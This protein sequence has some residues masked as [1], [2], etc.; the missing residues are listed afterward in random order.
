MVDYA[1]SFVPALTASDVIFNAGSGLL[2]GPLTLGSNEPVE[3]EL[4]VTQ[5]TAPAAG[6]TALSLTTNAETDGTRLRQGTVLHFG[7]KVAVVS[8]TTVVAA[9]STATSVPVEPLAA[10]GDPPSVVAAN[11]KASIWPLL[12]VLAPTDIPLTYTDEKVSSKNLT[13]GLQGAE[14]PVGVMAS[15]QIAI[16]N[17]PDDRAYHGIIYP[18][19]QSKVRIFAHIV[20]NNGNHL[21]GPVYVGAVTDAGGINEISRPTFTLDFQAPFAAPTRYEHLSTTQQTALNA[22]CK[23]SGL[24]TYS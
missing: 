1:T 3:H 17:R 24:P 10:I 16:N 22:V 19:S 6:D 21:W 15:I 5:A 12:S 11:S 23:L 20:K 14:V 13:F 8:D 9:G 2:V 4:T 18:A 7:S